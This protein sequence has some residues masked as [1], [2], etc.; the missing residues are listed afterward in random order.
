MKYLNFYIK[1]YRDTALQNIF[2]TLFVVMKDVTVEGLHVLLPPSLTTAF[3]Q[4]S[5][6]L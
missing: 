6:T 1:E 2:F 5:N 3:H 4:M